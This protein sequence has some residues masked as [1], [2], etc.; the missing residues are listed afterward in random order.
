M[1]GLNYVNEPKAESLKPKGVENKRPKQLALA[2]LLLALCS[3]Y[4]P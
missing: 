2:F 4:L 3:K 1:Q